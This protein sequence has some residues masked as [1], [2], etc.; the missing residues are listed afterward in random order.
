MEEL[1]LYVR[2]SH[3]QPLPFLEVLE[4]TQ[5]KVRTSN[6]ILPREQPRSNAVAAPM[7]ALN[8]NQAFARAAS[9]KTASRLSSKRKGRGR[10][11]SRK[12][13]V[14]DDVTDVTE[15]IAL[16]LKHAGYEVTTAN[17]AAKALQLAATQN[18]DLVISDIGMPEMNGYELAESL[19]SRS[20][21]QATPLIAV[22]GYT[23]YDDRGRS[24]QAGFDAHLTKP[25]NPSQLL[26]LIGQLL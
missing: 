19:R 16:F 24:L 25:I 17:S 23:E 12:V 15:M 4:A 22:T 20:D 3:F 18:F 14:V 6:A 21:Y 10:A 26:D 1:A 8:P 11:I 2:L 9:K 5:T 13:L 7:R